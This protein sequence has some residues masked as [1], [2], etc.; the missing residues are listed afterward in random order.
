MASMSGNA[1]LRRAA[2]QLE[3][4]ERLLLSLPKHFYKDQARREV[5]E[6]LAKDIFVI[7]QSI[8]EAIT[9]DDKENNAISWDGKERIE[10]RSG[11]DGNGKDSIGKSIR[12]DGKSK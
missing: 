5:L 10:I 6:K 8:E 2:N 12:R 11:R 9:W 1:K 3:N 7:K 4:A